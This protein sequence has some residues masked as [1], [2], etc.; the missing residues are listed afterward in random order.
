[1]RLYQAKPTRVHA[2]RI[3]KIIQIDH[4]KMMGTATYLLI[5]EENIRHDHKVGRDG[6]TPEVGDYMIFQSSS[7][8]YHC[9]REV[10][11]YRWLEVGKEPVEKLA[12]GDGRG[13][14]RTTAQMKGAPYGAIYVV[15]GGAGISYFRALATFLERQDLS[16]VGRDWLMAER[17]GGRKHPVVIDH[18]IVGEPV[19]AR[20]GRILEA[21]KGHDRNQ[22]RHQQAG[23]GAH[24]V[25]CSGKRS[26]SNG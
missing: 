12:A 17:R 20:A 19:P 8:I 15:P 24:L 22:D 5:L 10:F 26:F 9:P 25:G 7:D 1:M 18:Y 16:I 2:S 23:T 21:E 14:G 13:S 11:E 4:V 3:E 6:R